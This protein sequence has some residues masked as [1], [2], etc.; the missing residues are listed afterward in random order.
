[1][2]KVVVIGSTGT[3][4]SAIVS[5]LEAD[6]IVIK[7]SNSR[8]EYQVDMTSEESIEQLFSS[9]GSFDALIV[10]AGNMAFAA[11]TEMTTEQWQVGIESKLMGQ[12]NLTRKAIPH[13]NEG[14]SITL[15]S[16]ILTQQPIAWGTSASTIN[17]AVNHFAKAAATELPK[18]IRINVVSPTVVTESLPI[19]QDFFP[20][21]ESASATKV[22]N[23]YFKSVMGVQ[24]GQ[25]FEVFN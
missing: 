2:K 4:G 17:G 6:N 21:F 20:G 3:L 19:Y 8:G 12:I 1:M 11:F 7:V 10:A 9:I 22:A 5:Q 13:L 16:G 25:V 15:T 18:N 24:T 14:G 23:A